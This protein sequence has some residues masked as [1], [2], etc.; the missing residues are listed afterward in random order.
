[1][2][3]PLLHP[4]MKAVAPVRR[5]LGFRTL[6]NLLG[7][8]TNPAFASHQVIGV[9]DANYT[10][11]VAEAASSLGVKRAFVVHNSTGIDELATMGINKV[12]V[13]E[14]GALRT[15]TIDPRELGCS[16]CRSGDLKGGSAEDNAAIAL[17]ILGG[18]PGPGAETVAMN[19]A[20]GLLAVDM[21]ASLTEG[22]TLAFDTI[23]SGR[24][25]DKLNA[26][27]EYTSGLQHVA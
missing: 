15:F 8:L 25:L 18:T 12:S 16:P 11:I 13:F 27:V 20:L 10:E 5:E 14:N 4:A 1:M 23:K 19:A 17:G 21:V 24:A 9:F 6:F 2:F 26:F 3:A 7:P 22:M